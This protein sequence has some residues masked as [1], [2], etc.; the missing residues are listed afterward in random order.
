M[1][2]ITKYAPLEAKFQESYHAQT[3]TIPIIVGSLGTILARLLRFLKTI[4]LPDVI[5]SLQ[6][7]WTFST[8]CP[9]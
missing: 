4:G 7:F 1:T 3:E 6:T 8:F 2:K 9:N 5:G